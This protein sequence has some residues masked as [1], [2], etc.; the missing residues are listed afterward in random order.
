MKVCIERGCPKLTRGTRCERHEAE[1]QLRKASEYD[2]QR[3]S[4][5]ARGYDERHREW[6]AKVL[7]RDPI[8]VCGCGE[9]STVADHIIPIRDGGARF[10]LKNGQGMAESCHNAKR[11]RESKGKRRNL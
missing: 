7:K 8:C 3:P 1:F 4:P 10:D 6:R 2:A 5:A 9:P 11:G